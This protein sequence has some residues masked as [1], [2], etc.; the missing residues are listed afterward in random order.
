MEVDNDERDSQS[1]TVPADWH[2]LKKRDNILRVGSES[3]LLK[4]TETLKI[5][6]EVRF[7]V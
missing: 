5:K 2:A 7:L 3:K 1:W 4:M 6:E